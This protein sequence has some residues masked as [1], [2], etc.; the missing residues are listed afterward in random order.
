[1]SPAVKTVQVNLRMDPELKAAAEAAAAADR[2]TL[3]SWIEKMI[4]D[5]LSRQATLAEWTTTTRLRFVR[6]L[7]DTGH[8][9]ALRPGSVA[10]SY[11]IKH[12]GSLSIEPARLVLE[13]P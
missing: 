12:P 6:A 13:L 8:G 10:M 11:S 4:V 7:L 5:Q 2:R 3:T 1:M 9:D